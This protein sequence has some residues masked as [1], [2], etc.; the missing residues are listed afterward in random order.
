VLIEI[1]KIVHFFII[2]FYLARS[3]VYRILVAEEDFLQDCQQLQS[4]DECT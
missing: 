3:N 1:A 2:F 4:I